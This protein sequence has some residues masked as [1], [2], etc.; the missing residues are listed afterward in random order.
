MNRARI[1]DAFRDRREF[2]A[3]NS[4]VF[5]LADVD[6]RFAPGSGSGIASLVEVEALR[7]R[8]WGFSPDAFAPIAP[9]SPPFGQR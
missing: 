6:Q 8:G 9:K 4:R 3:E 2:A 1:I 5:D 7:S